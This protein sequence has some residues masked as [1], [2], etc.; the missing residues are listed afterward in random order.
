MNFNLILDKKYRYI[1]LCVMLKQ[2]N[3][4][5]SIESIPLLYRFCSRKCQIRINSFES[6]KPLKTV[7]RALLSLIIT[8]RIDEKTILSEDEREIMLE[9]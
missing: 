2:H 7:I 1:R 5:L 8:H 4:R 6:C 3:Y 9:I